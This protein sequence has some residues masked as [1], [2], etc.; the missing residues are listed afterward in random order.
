M[1][2]LQNESCLQEKHEQ[3]IETLTEVVTEQQT[4]KRI[5]STS[6]R[7][8]R[9]TFCISFERFNVSVE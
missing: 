8:L 3:V 6:P 2:D 5:Y 1:T 7:P 4:S 9:R